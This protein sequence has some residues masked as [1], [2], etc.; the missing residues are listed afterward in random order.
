MSKVSHILSHACPLS[1]VRL[2]HVLAEWLLCRLQGIDALPHALCYREFMVSYTVQP[3]GHMLGTCM[4]PILHFSR[5]SK[6][7]H[8]TVSKTGTI[9]SVTSWLTRI[10]VSSFNY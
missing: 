8:A 10:I 4:I 9:V 5:V 6:C 1:C 7:V 3:V 2:T